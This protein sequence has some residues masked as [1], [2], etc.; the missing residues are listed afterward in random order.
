MG[1][2]FYKTGT[3]LQNMDILRELRRGM[4][5]AVQG[6]SEVP[7]IGEVLSIPP[8]PDLHSKILIVLYDQER[9][10]HK[11]KWLRNF[12]KSVKEREIS[13]EDIVLYDFSLTSRGTIRKSTRE[14]IQNQK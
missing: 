10:V 12:T 13:I 14:Y 11:S 7:V 1:K 4:L 5:V 8:N 2:Q 3:V 9:A 6:K